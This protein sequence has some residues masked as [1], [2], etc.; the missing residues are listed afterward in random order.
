MAINKTI[1]KSTKSHGAMRNCIEY[2]LREDKTNR[3]LVYVTGPFSADN[4][5]YD[6]VYK[7]FLEEKKLWGKD[8]GRMYAHNIISW[9]KEENLT[10]QQAFAFGK[11]FV[12]KW[13]DGFQTLIGVHKDRD[14]VHLHLVTNTVSHEDGHKLHNS[15]KDLE[16][17]KEMTN[18]MC[19]EHGLTVAQ[20]GKDFHGNDLE[21]GHVRAWS[22]DKYHLLLNDQKKSHVAECALAVMETREHSCSK[23]EFV[24][25]MAI[26]GW[27]TTWIDS[28]KNITFENDEGKKVRD[29]NISKT[30]QMEISKEGLLNEFERQAEGRER[31]SRTERTDSGEFQLDEEIRTANSEFEE[32]YREVKAAIAGSATGTSNNDSGEGQFAEDSERG[33]GIVR[34]RIGKTTDSKSEFGERK[35]N[36]AGERI[37]LNERLGVCQQE[38]RNREE[39][40]KLDEQTH[41]RTRGRSR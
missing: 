3:G 4:I 30:F 18:Q 36:L 2:V 31:I 8:Y 11:E 9:H 16:R 5:T 39:E 15:K 40:R 32:Y 12:E 20:K 27:R 10:L 26:R 29:S 13:F 35:E 37:S 38:V 17:M 24:K 6:S 1:N 33:Q 14:H 22:K 19:V 41:T 25:G 7:S 28:R 21:E 23:G 34:G